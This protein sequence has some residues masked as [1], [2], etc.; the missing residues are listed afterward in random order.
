[1]CSTDGGG[2]VVG[3][4]AALHATLDAL[5]AEDVSGLPVGVLPE[6]VR[7]LV[8]VGHR[9]HAA[10]LDAVGAF[11]AAGVAAG[12]AQRSTKRWVEHHTRASA[13]QA[14]GLVSVARAVRDHLPAT[15]DALAAAQ[16]SA[17][18]V[19]AIA[20]VVRTVGVEHARAAEPV[21]LGL[22]RAAEP[23]VVRRA[24]AHLHATLDPDGA[25]AGLDRVYARRGVRLSVVGTRAYVD[26]VLDVES[27]E[28][29]ALALMPLM[30]PGPGDDRSA[31]ARRA[32]ALVDLARR[33]LD[34]GELPVLGGQ[35]PHL[36]VV[37]DAAAL[38]EG[39]GAATL[40]WTG[41]AVPVATVARWGCDARLRPVWAAVTRRGGWVPLA[42]GRSSRT[43]TAGQLVALRVRD[44]GCVYPGCARTAAFCDAHHVIH[45]AQGGVTDLDNL[46]LLCRHHHRTLHAGQ[47]RLDPLDTGP[48]PGLEVAGGPGGAEGRP[49]WDGSPPPS[50]HRHA[51][52]WPGGYTAPLQ[53]AADRSPPLR[54][55]G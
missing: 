48:P 24:A 22:A 54:P 43:V 38:A 36:S 29:L 28:V 26:G 42:V 20:A 13:G 19:G 49:G 4:V 31:A 3:L 21:L 27:A 12:T 47:W 45:W 1:M 50:V 44:G 7:G 17:A 53:T 39:R 52:V 33:A 46:V 25:Q 8:A 55:S 9:V 5:L 2:G 15:R 32:D 35:R 16:V 34:A 6:V 40:P 37:V 11:D 23:G 18:H 14:A 30:A 41:V 51:A 10:Q